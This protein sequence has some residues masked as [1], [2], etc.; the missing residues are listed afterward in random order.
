MENKQ[1]LNINDI[2]QD[3]REQILSVLRN[4]EDYRKLVKKQSH[5]LMIG[6][7]IK[8]MELGYKI[9]KCEQATL[10]KYLEQCESEIKSFE[11]LCKAMPE[12]DVHSLN[13]CSV[14]LIMLS[15]LIET[16]II[17]SNQILKRT[18][19]NFT[20]E[21]FDKLNELG[22]E[23]RKHVS[24]IDQCAKDEF[25]TNTYGDTADKLYE[26]ILNKSKSFLRKQEKH[27]AK[28]K[29]KEKKRTEHV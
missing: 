17:E 15:D 11:E 28:E 23:A 22:K 5:E 18:H 21:M 13:V 25:Y 2:P 1:K 7:P 12:E 27:H 10:E 9:A 4:T 20:L 16:F 14:A 29:L 8:A 26:M 6:N 19:P 24:M 3:V